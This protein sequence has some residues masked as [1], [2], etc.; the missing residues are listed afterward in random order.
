M[1]NAHEARGAGTASGNTI[2]FGGTTSTTPTLTV[3][4]RQSPTITT[5]PDGVLIEGRVLIAGPAAL[6]G[7][8]NIPV[9]VYTCEPRDTCLARP[10]IPLGTA[11]TDANGRFTL[12]I[13]AAV[14]QRRVLLLSEVFIGGIRCRALFTLRPLSL[15]AAALAPAGTPGVQG[16][17]ISIDPITEASVRLLEAA[18]LDNYG[19]EGIAAVVAAVKVANALTDFA[20]VGGEEANDTAEAVAA[21]DP[22]VQEALRTSLLC[23]GDCDGS[24]AVRIDELVFAVNLALGQS[25]AAERCLAAD[26]NRD[27]AVRVNELVRAVNYALNGCPG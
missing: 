26:P 24:G 22:L 4:P 14:A 19:D 6:T 8:A 11:M 9:N 20:G 21:S 23:V 16:P 12:R 25:A 17:E 1:P 2:D 15:A 13:P 5:S 18:G 3:T 10:G 7:A 27:G